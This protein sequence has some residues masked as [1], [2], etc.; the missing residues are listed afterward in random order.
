MATHISF[1]F[2]KILNIFKNIFLDKLVIKRTEKN[3]SFTGMEPFQNIYNV[4]LCL[5]CVLK[6]IKMYNEIPT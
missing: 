4:S 2:K 6:Y 5:L 3:G 1:F